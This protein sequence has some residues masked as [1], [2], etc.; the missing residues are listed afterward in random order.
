M[1]IHFNPTTDG[2]RIID[3]DMP[4][5]KGRI[6]VKPDGSMGEYQFKI[7]NENTDQA[8]ARER[9]GVTS[10]GHK[11]IAT[12]VPASLP[13]PAP[14]PINRF[15]LPGDRLAAAFESVGISKTSGCGCESHQAQMNAWWIGIEKEFLDATQKELMATYINR[16]GLT[17]A[18]GM[19]AEAIKRKMMVSPVKALR[20]VR[21]AFKVD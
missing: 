13:P 9:S 19:V 20:A 11:P 16:Y 15:E 14:P 18:G 2:G 21:R 3:I 5:G 12:A 17:I 4:L 8:F 1:H 6:V 10:N 7:L